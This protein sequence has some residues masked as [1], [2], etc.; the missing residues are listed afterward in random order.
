M[1]GDNGSGKS[2]LLNIIAEKLKL[3]PR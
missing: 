1:Y 3:N 2:T